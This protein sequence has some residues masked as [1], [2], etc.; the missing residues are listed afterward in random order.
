VLAGNHPVVATN[1]TLILNWCENIHPQQH[2]SAACR[3]A[4]HNIVDYR[5]SGDDV[6]AGI[7]PAVS[8]RPDVALIDVQE[9]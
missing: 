4:K 9:S 6:R 7:K 8:M 2:C 5:V 1:H 3:T